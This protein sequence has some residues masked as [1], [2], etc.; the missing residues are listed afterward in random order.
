[1][2]ALAIEAFQRLGEARGVLELWLLSVL[3]CPLCNRCHH[4]VI[5]VREV[6]V[7]CCI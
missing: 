1:M 7:R 3:H 4:L 2:E 6:R 5:F